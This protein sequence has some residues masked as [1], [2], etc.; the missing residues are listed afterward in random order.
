MVK[1]V[2]GEMNEYTISFLNNF[3]SFQKK[4]KKNKCKYKKLQ[5]CCKTYPHCICLL[6]LPYKK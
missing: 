1:M 6:Q 5:K 3:F 2:K 4:N